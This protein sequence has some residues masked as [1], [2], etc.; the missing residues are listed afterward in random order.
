MWVIYL[1][2]SLESSLWN[3]T[4]AAKSF[5]LNTGLS[6]KRICNN[7]Q[8]FRQ[9][10]ITKYFNTTTGFSISQTSNKDHFFFNSSPVLKC[11]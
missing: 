6:A 3:L 1:R 2:L 4:C 7:N 11:V 9:Y 5:N 8:F 10:S